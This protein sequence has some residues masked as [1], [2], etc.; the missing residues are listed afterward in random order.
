V[1]FAL[2]MSDGARSPYFLWDEPI[3]L[4][5]LRRKLT[6]GS[7][8]ERVRLAGKVLREAR[9]EEAMELVPLEFLVTHYAEIRRHLGRRRRFW[10][11]LLGEWRALGLLR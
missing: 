4:D 5:T 2:D 7:P 3:S 6:N 9:F 11:F 8:E 10:D 1:P